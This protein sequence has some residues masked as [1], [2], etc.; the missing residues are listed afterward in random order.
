MAARV[1]VIGVGMVGEQIIS[2]LKERNLPIDW[3]PRVYA[4]WERQ[5]ILAGETFQVE[6]LSADSFKNVDVAPVSYTHL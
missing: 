4:T 3:P 6:K 1:I 2:I 5:E